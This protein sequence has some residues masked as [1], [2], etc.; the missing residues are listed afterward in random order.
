MSTRA[1]IWW[2]VY[3]AASTP[4]HCAP[5]SLQRNR[6]SSDVIKPVCVDVTSERSVVKALVGSVM[7]HYRK[8]H[9]L[10]SC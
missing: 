2:R 3:N 9:C 5:L 1:T 8:L 7:A 10:V 6:A 4:S